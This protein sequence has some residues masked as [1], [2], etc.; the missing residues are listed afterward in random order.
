MTAKKVLVLAHREELL[1][2]ACNQIRKYNPD[3]VNGAHFKN[4]HRHILTTAYLGD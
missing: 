1:L 2:Q 3:K 4:R